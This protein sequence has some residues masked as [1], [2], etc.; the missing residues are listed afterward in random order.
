MTS[1][2]LY[3]PSQIAGFENDLR[4]QVRGAV[5]FDEVNVSFYRRLHLR[6]DPVAVFTPLDE[7][8]VISAV[9]T[10]AEHKIS[11]LCRGGGTS[12]AGQ[13]VGASLVIDF[14]KHMNRILEVN[15]EERWARVQPGVVRDEFN[16]AIA[17]HGLHYA[18]DPATANRANIGGILAN[19]SSGT[20]SIVYGRRSTSSRPILLTDGTI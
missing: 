8:D 19:N 2:S 11:I 4:A 1:S 15:V 20:K 9:T 7:D 12:L 14:S 3:T 17:K 10:A 5:S 18:I 16:T 6:I 13:T